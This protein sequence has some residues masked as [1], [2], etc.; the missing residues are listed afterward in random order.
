LSR[1]FF[2][3][4]KQRRRPHAG[5]AGGDCHH[6][7]G[8]VIPASGAIGNGGGRPAI[9]HGR[10]K[11]TQMAMQFRVM[12]EIE[13]SSPDTFKIGF[14]FSDEEESGIEFYSNH[15]LPEDVTEKLGALAIDFINNIG[16]LVLTKLH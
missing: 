15:D 3:A 12:V 14:E 2:W 16:D 5:W 11:E 10:Q 1:A 6:A 7:A 9:G 4:A 13:G 8:Q